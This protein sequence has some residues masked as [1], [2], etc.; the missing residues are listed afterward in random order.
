M[1]DELVLDA[2]VVGRLFFTEAGS[3]AARAFVFG[4]SFI[5]PDLI[6]FE[7]ANLSARKQRR[8]DAD[9]ANAARAVASVDDLLTESVPGRML[10][11]RAFALAVDH[12]FSAYDAAYLALAEMRATI[13]VTADVKFADRARTAGF[14]DL[15]QAI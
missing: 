4:Q 7:V 15:V 13:V 3:D 14:G 9:T 5:A 12:G 8:G 11:E 1:A 6:H 10:A 2:S